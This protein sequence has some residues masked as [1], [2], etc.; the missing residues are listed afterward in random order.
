MK[1]RVEVKRQ[2]TQY[3]QATV[4]IDLPSWMSPTLNIFNDYVVEYL[5]SQQEES[6]PW[7]TNNQ[8]ESNYKVDPDSVTYFNRGIE[9]LN[10]LITL[11][12]KKPCNGF[13][14]IIGTM[15]PNVSKEEL[16]E[17]I[18]DNEKGLPYG[19]SDLYIAFDSTI[20]KSGWSYRVHT[21]NGEIKETEETGEVMTGDNPA[22]GNSYEYNIDEVTNPNRDIEDLNKLINLISKIPYERYFRMHGTMN[23]SVS[24]LELMKWIKSQPYGLPHGGSDLVTVYRPASNFVEWSYKVHTP[25]AAS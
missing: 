15:D 13:Y 11:S 8:C 14:R 19:G 1:V 7:D 4:E 3:Q 18:E 20:N 23:P 22:S 16:M 10:K 6:I 24:K 9:E 12:S 17:W 25:I 2:V 21:G 5:H